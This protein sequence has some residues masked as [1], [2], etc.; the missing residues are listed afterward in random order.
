MILPSEIRKIAEHKGVP[1]STIDKDWVLGHLLAEICRHEWAQN[2]LLF[3][4]GTCLTI[5][6]IFYQLMAIGGIQL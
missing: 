6:I 5:T 2:N 3:K 4:G 1:T